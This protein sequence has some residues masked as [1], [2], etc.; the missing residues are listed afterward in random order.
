MAQTGIHL[1]HICF[2]KERRHRHLQCFGQPFSLVENGTVGHLQ[3]P[4]LKKKERTIC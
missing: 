2:D 3:I 4:G 1:V